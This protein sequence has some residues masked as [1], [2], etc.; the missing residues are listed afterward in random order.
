MRVCEFMYVCLYI[1]IYIYIYIH[2]HTHTHT[3]KRHHLSLSNALGLSWFCM[4]TC[5]Q[6]CTRTH[7]LL[8]ENER[9]ST[10]KLVD[11]FSKCMHSAT[12][13]MMCDRF[14]C[15]AFNTDACCVVLQMKLCLDMCAFPEREKTFPH[16]GIVVLL[17]SVC[18]CLRDDVVELVQGLLG[19]HIITNF[20]LSSH[21]KPALL[22]LGEMHLGALVHKVGCNPRTCVGC[23]MSEFHCKCTAISTVASKRDSHECRRAA[24]RPALTRWCRAC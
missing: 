10:A 4:Y 7:P 18:P 22:R 19:F 15:C 20:A 8:K 23:Q 5:M 16:P 11:L 12:T 1:Y 3:H 21:G 9:R 14:G 17:E 13:P 6:M 24:S 2:T